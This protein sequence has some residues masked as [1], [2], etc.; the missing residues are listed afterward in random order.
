MSC[1]V[2]QIAEAERR[3]L[4]DLT[5]D[6]KESGLHAVAVQGVFPRL[7]LVQALVCDVQDLRNKYE[8][9]TWYM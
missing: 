3:F 4:L 6:G 7:R 8:Q 1:L 9:C 2:I 5:E